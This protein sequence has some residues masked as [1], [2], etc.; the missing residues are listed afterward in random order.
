MRSRSSISLLRIRSVSESN[1][2]SR[3]GPTGS[4]SSLSSRRSCKESAIAKLGV[5]LRNPMFAFEAAPQ[6]IEPIVSQCLIEGETAKLTC[7][8][9][10]RPRP[11]VIW[12]G[13]NSTVLLPNY[14]LMMVEDQDGTHSLEITNCNFKDEGEYQC[15]ATNDGGSVSCSGSLR[16]K[17]KP[18]PPGRPILH[19]VHSTAVVLYWDPPQHSGNCLIQAYT[20]EYAQKGRRPVV[21]Q[22]AAAY[23]LTTFFKV[24]DLPS[25]QTFYFRVSANNEIGLSDPS[26]PSDGADLPTDTGDGE[27][28]VAGLSWHYNFDSTFSVLGELGRGRF[29]V[30]KQC[31]D[32]QHQKEVAAKCIGKKH[33][34]LEQ[35]EQEVSIVRALSHPAIYELMSCY[36][37]PK[38]FVLIFDFISSGRLMDH[39]I[40]L[41]KLT[42]HRIAYYVSQ[43][44][45]VLHYL[46]NCGIAHL[47]IKPE[48]LLI[49]LSSLIPSIKL[50]DFGDAVNIATSQGEHTLLGNPEFAA[51]ELITEGDITTFTDMWSVGVLTYVLLSGI[52]PFLDESIE[53][54]CINI[55]KV[56]F[57]FP[58]TYFFN[59]SRNAKNFISNLLKGDARARLTSQ[60]GMDSPWIKSL[61]GK[62]L[63]RSAG[64]EI[65]KTRLAD[66]IERRKTHNDIYIVPNMMDQH[67]GGKTSTV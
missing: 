30:V 65:N 9:S 22:V 26:E 57:C 33:M 60:G 38:H 61:K 36:E 21:W 67:I 40:S 4:S 63:T 55:M 42:E 11:P 45:D 6:F 7:R 10:G 58:D 48:N 1:L 59:I 50:I 47:D 8:A 3:H 29:S 51:P 20:V 62:S 13:P 24:E 66:F 53:E 14:R 17:G 5:K 34:G 35:V 23:V 54:T 64:T 25:G 49:D 37:T 16:V 15:V 56:D 32:Q 46:H 44:L 28:Q 31:F 27:G 2:G 41:A 39:L 52:S 19:E 18:G 12:K 43:V